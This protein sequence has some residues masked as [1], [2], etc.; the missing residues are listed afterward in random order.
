MIRKY[1]ITEYM[2]LF[3][4]LVLGVLSILYI[5]SFSTWM[6]FNNI[7]KQSSYTAILSIGMLFVLVSGEIDLSIGSQFTLY[8]MLCAFF[9]QKELPIIVVVILVLLIACL[10]GSMIGFVIS[11]MDKR[12]SG[13]VSRRSLLAT[14]AISL[15]IEGVIE[16]VT[17]GRRLQF[18]PYSFTHGYAQWIGMVSTVI[19][20]MVLI[21]F[22]AALF[23]NKT[24][25]GRFL[26]YVGA[27]PYAAEKAGISIRLYKTLGF[28]VSSFLTAISAIFYLSWVGVASTTSGDRMTLDVLTVAALAGVSF[29][30]GRGRVIP[31]ILSAI[32]LGLLSASLIGFDIASYYQKIIKGV[33]LFAAIYLN[34]MRTDT[35]SF[36]R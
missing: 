34:I 28:S 22:L 12:Y 21:G 5:P 33:I 29:T 3:L 2:P 26:Y 24:Y 18:L 9:L 31:V 30:G 20:V 1:K 8:G 7:L 27:N 17:E 6:N 36:S 35:T 16:F 15:I 19:I 10:L 11:G 25:H 4:L 13:L 14:L 23:L 32:F